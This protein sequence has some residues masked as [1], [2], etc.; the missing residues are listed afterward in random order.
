M[1][2]TSKSNLLVLLAALS[3]VLSACAGNAAQAQVLQADIPRQSAP[4]A[5][6]ADMQVLAQGNTAFALDLYQALRQ[7]GGNLF[8][9]PYS[10][11]LALAMTYAGARNQTE[12][13]MARALH[14]D[15][16]Q[17]RLHPAF[18]ALD[19]A[20]T[21]ET[22]EA[23]PEEVTP[24]QLHIASSLWGQQDEAFLDEFLN[25]LAANYGAGMRLV[26]FAGDA[27]AA[28]LT[29]NR[30]I[31]DQTAEKIQDMIP[32]GALDAFTRLVLANA[33]YFKANWLN[34]FPISNTQPGPFTH[35]DGSQEQVPMMNQLKSFQYAQGEGY[36][37]LE[38]PYH[39][40]EVSMVILLP[41][42]GSFEAFESA[43]SP[44]LLE[45]I[46]GGMQSKQVQL[47]LPKF[48][49]ESR[50]DLAKTL[51]A[52]GMPVAFTPPDGN[53]ADFSGIDGQRNLFIG[54]VFHKAFV[55]VDEKGTEAAAATVVEIQVSSAP[56]VEVQFNV[57]R[58]FL[59]LI[60]H[61]ASQ[62]IL[63]VG[64]VLDPG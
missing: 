51:K 28:R 5:P 16:P 34:A 3:W 20:L 62:S 40:G 30:W 63:F 13:Q 7:E 32:A 27:E 42:A 54:D 43:L 61:N 9:S 36:Q 6:P 4:A 39:G 59:F 23:G 29:I 55:A 22:Q 1:K 33:I 45:Q 2:A 50:F 57:D 53:G 10:I 14:F 46:Q 64:R 24:F 25:T 17:E 35:L 49:Y 56:L 38:L 15:L 21:G 11:S 18:N 58:P 19:L 41:D 60:R 37:A 8:Y 48:Q 26:N 44:A 31:S 12:A 47:S 52:L